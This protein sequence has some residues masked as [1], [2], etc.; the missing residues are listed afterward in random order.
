MPRLLALTLA[1]SLHAT[2]LAAS[3]GEGSL[4]GSQASM[5]EQNRVARGHGLPFL[6]TPGQIGAAVAQ[7]A[8]VPLGNGNDY[9]V[10]PSVRHPY[11][12]PA[13]RS[14][15]EWL[16]AGYRE[17]CGERLVVTSAV[18]ALTQQPRNA[19]EL[20]VHPAGMA[21]DLRVSG[22][23]ACREW[24]EG[25]LL[26][27]EAQGVADGIRE[28]SP[29]HYHVAVYPEPFLEWIEQTRSEELTHAAQAPILAALRDGADGSAGGGVETGLAPAVESSAPT[30]GPGRAAGFSFA[31]TALIGAVGGSFLRRGWWRGRD[32]IGRAL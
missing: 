17:A 21:V 27:L 23:A 3:S 6:R 8:L 18:R 15:V 9:E 24:L 12:V 25:K 30:P 1:L 10:A 20:S 13:V 11:V 19:S 26:E 5:V 7:G 2:A 22:R 28:R 32:V 31:V 16:G 29:P 14:F 4:R